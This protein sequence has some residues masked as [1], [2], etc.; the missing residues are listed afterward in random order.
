[1]ARHGVFVAG[2][3]Q[4]YN[5]FDTGHGVFIIQTKKKRA[6]KSARLL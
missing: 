6:P 4:P 2:I 3:A 5:Q 1:M